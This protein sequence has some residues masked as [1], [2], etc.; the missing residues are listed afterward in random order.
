MPAIAEPPQMPM[1]QEV[2][3]AIDAIIAIKPMMNRHV[4]AHTLTLVDLASLSLL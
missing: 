4:H 1:S 3:L 2:V